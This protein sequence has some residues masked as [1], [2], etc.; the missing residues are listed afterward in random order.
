MLQYTRTF[1]SEEMIGCDFIALY[2]SIP[3]NILM[4]QLRLIQLV[5]RQLHS[6]PKEHAQIN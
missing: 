4:L 1:H 5:L 6:P 3:G 2:E